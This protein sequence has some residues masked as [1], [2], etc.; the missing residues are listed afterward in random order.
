MVLEA[1]SFRPVGGGTGET[2]LGAWANFSRVSQSMGRSRIGGKD[3]G[4][5]RLEVPHRIFS[6]PQRGRMAGG[7][8][9][10]EYR[11]SGG[12]EGEI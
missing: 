2:R 10:K 1:A 9:G 5:L 6:V 7:C 4:F 3:G 11:Q 12:D 8:G